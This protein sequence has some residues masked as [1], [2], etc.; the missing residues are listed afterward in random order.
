MRPGQETKEPRKGKG[1][2][3]LEQ[4]LAGALGTRT[5]LTWSPGRESQPQHF[6]APQL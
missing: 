4:V 3:S 1:L 2:S 6:L 5:A